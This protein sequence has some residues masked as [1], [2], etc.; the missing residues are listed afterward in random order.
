[1][2]PSGWGGT[3]PSPLFLYLLLSYRSYPFKDENE[4]RDGAA[5]AIGSWGIQWLS[6]LLCIFY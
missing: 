5:C 6:P 2:P 3:L 4:N 1:M